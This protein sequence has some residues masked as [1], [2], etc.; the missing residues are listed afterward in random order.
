M[1]AILYATAPA[2]AAL[3]GGATAVALRA[4]FVAP[5]AV[6]KIIVDQKQGGSI[7]KRKLV[8]FLSG[9]DNPATIW[10]F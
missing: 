4:P 10:E 5:P 6:G 1:N 3:A 2:G 8:H 9:L 7:S